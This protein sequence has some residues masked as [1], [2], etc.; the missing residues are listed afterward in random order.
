MSAQKYRYSADVNGKR[1]KVVFY[2]D[3]EEWG[4]DPGEH[5]DISDAE[6][7][8]DNDE[9]TYRRFYQGATD[10]DYDADRT[11]RKLE[12]MPRSAWRTIDSED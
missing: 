9:P 12:L 2:V 6:L 5:I 4:A 7:F 11:A 3:P 10:A 1:R 8:I